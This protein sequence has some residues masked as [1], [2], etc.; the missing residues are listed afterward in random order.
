MVVDDFAGFTVLAALTDTICIEDTL[1]GAEY[2]PF[3][4]IVPSG[5]LIVHVTAE[6]TDPLTMAVNCCWFPCKTVIAAGLTATE[7][8]VTGGV[9]GGGGGGGA[10][11]EIVALADLV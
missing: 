10:I 5:G 2:K 11:R 3:D 6:L 4:V 9:G 8:I 7:L 1:P